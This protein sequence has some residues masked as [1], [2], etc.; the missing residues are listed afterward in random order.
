MPTIAELLLA[1]IT[2]QPLSKAEKREVALHVLRLTRR[3]REAQRLTDSRR[4]D[5][6]DN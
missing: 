6:R 2:D 4:R 5:F 3:V 1:L